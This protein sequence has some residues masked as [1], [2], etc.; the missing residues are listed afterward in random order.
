MGAAAPDL[1]ESHDLVSPVTGEVLERIRLASREEIA[2][3]ARRLACGAGESSTEDVFSFF[4]RLEEELVSRR[5]LFIRM[6]IA[7]TGFIV[8][9]AEETVDSAIDFLSSFETFV[10]RPLHPEQII[11]HSYSSESRRSMRLTS[12][13][14]GVIAALVPQNASL[15]LGITMIASALYAGSRILLRPSLQTACTGTLLGEAVAASNPPGGRVG[16]VNCLAGRFL[17]ACCR[18]EH[19]DVIHYVGSNQ[20]ALSVLNQTFSAGKVCLL[21]G[22]GNGLLYVDDSVPV[23][24]AARLITEGAT[25]FNGETCTS[26]NGVLIE[27]SMYPSLRAALVEAFAALDVGNPFVSGTHVGPLFSERQAQ[28]LRR[29]MLEAQGGRILIGADL[30]GAYFGP[31]IVEGVALEDPLVREGLFGPAIWI[32]PV[33][34]GNLWSWMRGNRFPLSDTI[35]SS[36]GDV[37]REFAENSRAARVCVNAD[38]SVESMFEPW[39]GYPPGSLN[40]VSPWIEKYRQVYQLDGRLDEI[41]TAR[42][43][44]GLHP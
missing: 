33:R 12:R 43:N 34:R 4:R 3:E 29:Q 21:D 8:R 7:E 17:E 25:R 30:G 14:F 41:S 23:E 35:L 22:Q 44:P 1:A 15:T 42:D 2:Q 37:I 39:G 18:S 32:Q 24:E 13:S 26:V 5:D 38:P 28:S 16:I 11:Q 27:E 31:A 9:D 20:H 19:V 36:R 6:T 40:P 10:E